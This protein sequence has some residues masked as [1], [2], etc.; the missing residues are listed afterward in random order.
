VLDRF[1][2]FSNRL[3]L[4]VGRALF[5]DT[6]VQVHRVGDKHMIVDHRHSDA[7]SIRGCVSSPMYADLL[8]RVTLPKRLSVLDVGSNVGGFPLLLHALGHE[9]DRLTCVEFNPATHVRLHFNILSNWP[10]AT[11]LNRAITSREGEVTVSLGSGNTG[12]SLR[13]SPGGAGE[14]RTIK[15]MRLDDIPHE[16]PIDILKMDI[17]HAEVDVLL[18]PGHE[19]TLAR[20]AVLVIEIHPL[21]HAEAIHDAIAATGLQHVAG[22]DRLIGQHIFAR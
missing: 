10:D 1:R 12:D 8:G 22:P 2:N 13:G 16:G 11:V 17:E 18:N 6:K 19:A 20:T 7:G 9:I 3:E 4:A 15:T 5:R 21:E 14:V